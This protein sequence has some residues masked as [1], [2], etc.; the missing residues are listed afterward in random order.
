MK[1]ETTMEAAFAKAGKK[2]S[3][4]KLVFIAEWY[5]SHSSRNFDS[6][7]DSFW[8]AI[9]GNAELMRAAFDAH[10]KRILGDLLKQHRPKET[11]RRQPVSD[12]QYQ[13]V[14][15]GPSAGGDQSA[16]DAPPRPVAPPQPTDSAGGHRDSDA[17]HVRAAPLPARPRTLKGHILAT[18][19]IVRSQMDSYMITLRQGSRLA[20]GDMPVS[21]LAAYVAHSY[22][23]ALTS[24]EENEV[25]R[26]VLETVKAQAHVPA[27]A[28][29]R[30]VM[31]PKELD[32][33]INAAQ[34]LARFRQK[35]TVID[36]TPEPAHA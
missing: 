21:R 30:E 14:P 35:I 13:N 8:A 6:D 15:S 19:T 26:H 29:V 25:V 12:T 33:I 3:R 10:Y 4:S 28:K 27:G 9:N 5:A 22:R 24:I 23:H 7:V 34:M 20:I 36:M 16:S 31:D 18:E 11:G 17:Q 32:R 1:H 2:S